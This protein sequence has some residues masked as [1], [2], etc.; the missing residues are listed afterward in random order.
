MNSRR[1]WTAFGET[2]T[3]REWADDHRCSVSHGALRQRI[4]RGMPLAEAIVLPR[5]PSG[6]EMTRQR[7]TAFGETL[8]LREWA[9]DPRCSVCCE[10]L[11]QRIKRG[12]PLAEAIV[13]PRQPSGRKMTRQR[14]TAFGETLTLREWAADPR[15]SV[16]HETIRQRIK[17][18]MP[19]AEAIVLPRQPSGRKRQDRR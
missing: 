12:M 3:L 16:S 14:W 10:A 13:L 19:L 4:K 18:G 5:Q 11:R 6:R 7:W 2:L 8:T 15:C 17:R 9:A 1:N